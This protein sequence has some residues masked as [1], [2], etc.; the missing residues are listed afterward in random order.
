MIFC[1]NTT[2]DEDENKIIKEK[3]SGM[4]VFNPIVS[5]AYYINLKE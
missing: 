4:S 5:E 2:K 3:I 1:I